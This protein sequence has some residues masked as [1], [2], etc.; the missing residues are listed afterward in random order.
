MVNIFQTR[1]NEFSFFLHFS[2]RISSDKAKEGIALPKNNFSLPRGFFP[3]KNSG[4]KNAKTFVNKSFLANVNHIKKIT[5]LDLIYCHHS[6]L[7]SIY[8]NKILPNPKFWLHFLTKILSY[9][10]ASGSNSQLMG[11][12]SYNDSNPSKKKQ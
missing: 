9:K 8:T 5:K 6:P 7:F 10:L 1:R 2:V 12:N 3:L 4:L 11:S